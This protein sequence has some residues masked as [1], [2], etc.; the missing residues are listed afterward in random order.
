MQNADSLQVVASSGAE[1]DTLTVVTL[2]IAA[3]GGL[4]GIVAT[5]KF[6]VE[7]P[8]FEAQNLFWMTWNMVHE[9]GQKPDATAIMFGLV[10]T[11]S[12]RDVLTPVKFNFEIKI[13]HEWIALTGYHI[14]DHVVGELRR[15]G[16]HFEEET[17]VDLS[18]KVPI[19][20]PRG[21][22]VSGHLMFTTEKVSADKIRSVMVDRI[23]KERLSHVNKNVRLTCVDVFSKEHSVHLN[24]ASIRRESQND[25]SGPTSIR[26]ALGTRSEP[27]F[28]K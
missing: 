28:R 20:I 15:G 10:I 14:D 12:G 18:D 11:N 2:M 5:Y 16:Y 13:D 6:F 22:P 8:K 23:E 27:K 25:V 26:T 4:P 24:T 1:W 17:G 21:M 9:P 3:L 19:V 7:K